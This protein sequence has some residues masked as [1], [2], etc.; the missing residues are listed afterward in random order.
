MEIVDLGNCGFEDWMG[1][2]ELAGQSGIVNL[3]LKGTK[4][5]EEAKEDGFDEFKSKVRSSYVL[6]REKQQLNPPP[7]YA[8]HHH[9]P[10]SP[11]PRWPALRPKVL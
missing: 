8:A 11:H 10:Q 2:K 7:P 3:G 1:L 4:V 5:A 9:P 6:P